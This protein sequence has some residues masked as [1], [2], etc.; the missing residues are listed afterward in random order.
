VSTNANQFGAAGSVLTLKSGALFTN[1][2]FYG[3]D[4]FVNGVKRMNISPGSGV[5]YFYNGSGGDNFGF[6]IN[7]AYIWPSLLRIGEA[8]SPISLV[9][10]ATAT[11]QLGLDGS[12]KP[13]TYTLKAADGTGTDKPGGDMVLAAG[14]STGSGGPGSIWMS[15]AFPGGSGSSLNGY[16]TRNYI[17]SA[18]SGMSDGSFS[19]L[20]IITLPVGAAMGIDLFA[21]TY[22]V[23]GNDRIVNSDTL[24][25][26]AFN[27]A[28]T[29]SSAISGYN[30]TNT[31][32]SMNSMTTE[33]QVIDNADNT[34]SIR[35][36]PIVGVSG[37]TINSMFQ[38]RI[39][40]TATADVSVP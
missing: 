21:T 4:V 25:F 8:A 14:K 35:I 1:L 11:L 30:I 12:T 2:T 26:S 6:D 17:A 37:W 18:P 40:S 39:N 10:D 36:K 28:G 3:Q 19:T 20:C 31:V 29:I 13:A 16:V 27:I 38:L 23:N 15:T 5:W 33:F 34:L 9:K 24:N 7:G 22:G 32:A